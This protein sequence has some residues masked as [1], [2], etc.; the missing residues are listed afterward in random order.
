[1]P[2]IRPISDLRNSA[3]EISD[4]CK[5]TR[6]PVYITRNGTGDMV[7]MSMEMFERRE[8]QLELYA[9]LAEAEAEAMS[10]KT[11]VDFEEFAKKLRRK[12]HGTI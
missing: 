7:I 10:G 2:H 6:E 8:A 3:N 9:N 4:L 1:M 5:S 11:G 12:I